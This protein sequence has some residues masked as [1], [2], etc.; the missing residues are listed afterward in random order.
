MFIAA[1]QYQDL[2]TGGHV[3]SS[4]D[5]KEVWTL[6]EAEFH[7]VEKILHVNKDRSRLVTL[8]LTKLQAK[9]ECDSWKTLQFVYMWIMGNS[10]FA[11]VKWTINIWN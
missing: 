3:V 6:I 11:R 4:S 5:L 9:L 7:N 8:M 2:P 10:I 1:K